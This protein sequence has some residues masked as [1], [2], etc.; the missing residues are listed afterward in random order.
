MIVGYKTTSLYRTHVFI[1]Y[2]L[3]LII[4]EN[5]NRRMDTLLVYTVYINQ[6]DFPRQ[7]QIQIPYNTASADACSPS[8][9]R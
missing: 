5:H 2:I 1:L 9:V 7:D 6:H 4:N 8:W 3:Y